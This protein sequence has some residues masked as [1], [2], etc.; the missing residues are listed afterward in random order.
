M[1]EGKF[2]ANGASGYVLKPAN[3]Q[4]DGDLNSARSTNGA[5]GAV[6]LAAA[7]VVTPQILHLRIISG[8]QLPR[9]RGS[10]VKPECTS[11][12]PFVVIEVFG[13]PADCAEERTKTV[14]N[15]S[16]WPGCGMHAH[17][18]VSLDY[19]P[20]WDESFQFQITSPELAL[21]RFMVLDDDYIGDDF[22]AQYTIPFEC[23]QS[24]VLDVGCSFPHTT[25]TL[26]Y[27]H[28]ALLN[29]EGEPI[30]HCSLFIHIAVT[31]RRG[32]GVGAV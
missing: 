16:R 20:S 3:M 26:G 30:E 32:G 29:N 1:Q 19:A 28:V 2:A 9:P 5:A 15:D 24:G 18:H 4:A 11:A 17:T 27:R 12:D 10:T 13:V 21:V 7:A 31:N 14:R 25:T 8:Q 23:L 22:I 6:H